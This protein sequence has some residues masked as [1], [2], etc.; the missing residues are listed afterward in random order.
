MPS[1]SS[2]R[3]SNGP[4]RRFAFLLATSATLRDWLLSVKPPPKHRPP[5]AA[6]LREAGARRSVRIVLARE[7]L[8]QRIHD[9]RGAE[10][11]P[12]GRLRQAAGKRRSL[13]HVHQLA[14]QKRAQ[15]LTLAHGGDGVAPHALII[16]RMLMHERLAAGE[17]ACRDNDAPSPHV[18]HRCARPCIETHPARRAVL[19]QNE[20]DRPMARRKRSAFRREGVSQRHHNALH[21]AEAVLGQHDSRIHLAVHE[22]FRIGELRPV[23]GCQAIRPLGG[24]EEQG[25]CEI[26]IIVACSAQLL[27]C[28]PPDASSTVAFTPAS[29]CAVVPAMR[30]TPFDSWFSPPNRSSSSDHHNGTLRLERV[31]GGRQPR[32]PAAHDQQHIHVSI[33]GDGRLPHY[34]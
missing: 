29:C 25:L 31:H 17:P 9:D 13:V 4:I 21:V 32:H 34:A 10:Q 15:L 8:P 2:S 28:A 7:T 33:E 18:E 3:S 16:G 26:K 23:I 30:I 19:I 27:F 6:L 12:G 11:A 20:R 14:A 24:R 1:A 22:G 5:V